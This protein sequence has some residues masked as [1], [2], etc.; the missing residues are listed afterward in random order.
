MCIYTNQPALKVAEHDITCW[1]AVEVIIGVNN[2]RVTITPYAAMVLNND[3]INGKSIMKPYDWM[4]ANMI[5][6]SIDSEL[7]EC[8]ASS[9]QAEITKDLIHTFAVPETRQEFIAIAKEMCS[10]CDFLDRR[11]YSLR[12]SSLKEIDCPVGPMVVEMRLCECVIPAGTK[13]IEGFYT[14]H[15]GG[16]LTRSYASRALRFTGKYI[17][18]ERDVFGIEMMY[19]LCTEEHAQAAIEKLKTLL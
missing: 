14:T 3:T 6:K 2:E 18:T 5:E 1:K 4:A 10:L 8:S 15:W 17:N 11:D 16:G 9:V 12:S 19:H 13:Y 7:A